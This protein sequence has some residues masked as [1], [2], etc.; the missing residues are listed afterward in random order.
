MRVVVDLDDVLADLIACLL[1][2]HHE[3]IGVKLTR[4]Q[5]VG[6]D[7]F[8]PE[9]HD[10]IRYGGA[11]GTLTPIPGAKEFLEWLKKANDVFIVTYRGE[12]EK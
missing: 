6:W 1:Q 3:M 10:R 8:P 4:N 5:A 7:V 11:Y 12:I 2:T 9:V